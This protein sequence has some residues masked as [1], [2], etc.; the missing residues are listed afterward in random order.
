MWWPV[1]TYQRVAPLIRPPPLCYPFPQ[2]FEVYTIYVTRTAG[3]GRV[4]P[5][6]FYRF[7]LR[8][9]EINRTFNQLMS[10][11]KL[12][13]QYAATSHDEARSFHPPS[14]APQRHGASGD[15]PDGG[16]PV[17]PW[18]RSQL[19]LPPFVPPLFRPHHD[20]EAIVRPIVHNMLQCAAIAAETFPTTEPPR[21]FLV[22]AEPFVDANLTGP[23]LADGTGPQLQ[24]GTGPQLR[25]VSH[26]YIEDRSIAVSCY[27]DWPNW[28]G[29]SG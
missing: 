21:Q 25:A 16:H 22:L 12:L 26:I 4:S 8:L 18:W 2:W 11:R 14:M 23:Q 15:H 29:S 5:V 27:A 9:R 17:C 6:E 10:S 1:A 3:C 13:Q 24:A 20:D 28:H 19:S 7:R